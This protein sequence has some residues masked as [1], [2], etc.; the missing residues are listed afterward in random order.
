MIIC[1]LVFPQTILIGLKNTKIVFWASLL[2][3]LLNIA[4]SLFL[5]QFYGLVGIALGTAF[6]HILEKIFMI[7]YNYYKLGISPKEYIPISWFLF[8]SSLITIVFVLIDHKL[9]LL[10]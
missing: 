8:Y 2:E 10:Y 3:I 1:R 4:A 9:L 5:F 7:A 6:I